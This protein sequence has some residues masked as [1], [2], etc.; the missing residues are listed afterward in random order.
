MPAPKCSDV[1]FIAAWHKLDGKIQDIAKHLGCAPQNVARRRRCL[2]RNHGIELPASRPEHGIVSGTRITQRLKVGIPNGIMVAFSDAHM[3]QGHVSAAQRACVKLCKKLKP[4]VLVDVGDTFDGA[5]ISRHPP[6]GWDELPTVASE[7]LAVAE[8]RGEIANAA[9]TAEKY[10]TP[11]NH[12]ERF[13]R[14]LAQ[15]ANKLEGVAGTTL[16][17]RFPDWTMAWALEVNW[18]VDPVLI[19]HNWKGGTHASH[20]NAANTSVHFIS[21][22]DHGQK[23]APVTN[24]RGTFYGINP[25]VFA[26]PNG[27]Q[28]KYVRG[29]PTNWRSGFAVLTF[30]SGHLLPPELVTIVDGKAYF[31]GAEL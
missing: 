13:D 21:G 2:E 31:R 23:I 24:E 17:E 30:R 8:Q 3:W 27:P 6:L 15:N 29:R 28:F 11:G 18:A 1:E 5:S 4:D 12:C 14:Y 25:G 20:N 10:W 22:H 9:K 16:S 7:L 19:T 26:D